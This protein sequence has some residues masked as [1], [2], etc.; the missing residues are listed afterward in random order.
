MKKL[1]SVLLSASMILTL[2]SC[3]N[4]NNTKRTRD[5]DEDKPTAAASKIEKSEEDT[6]LETGS[7]PG[8]FSPDFTFSTTDR[9]GQL[10]SEQIFS[11]SQLTMVNFWEPWCGPCV[12]EMPDIEKL[13]ENYKDK[14][15]QVIGVY[16]E[17]SMESDVTEILKDSNIRYL[18]L[19]YTVEFDQ[20]QTGYVPT[21]IFVDQNGH[22]LTLPD[23]EQSAIG[24]KSYD[25]WA[26]TV[27]F[28]LK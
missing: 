25:E 2:A 4:A 10:Y 12:N 14:G 26:S 23:G 6:S 16:S 22:V 11:N 28:F 17:T 18:I 19:N 15:L 21:T 24:S 13:Y 1:V 9:N 8:S 5:R 3:G 20:F 7:V 27:E